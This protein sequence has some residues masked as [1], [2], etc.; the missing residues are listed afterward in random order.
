M[1]VVNKAPKQEGP[2][3]VCVLVLGVLEVFFFFFSRVFLVKTS[4]FW[5]FWGYVAE[6]CCLLWGAF[7]EGRGVLVFFKKCI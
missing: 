1:L 2:L 3:D 5:Q 4:L 6:V 7:G